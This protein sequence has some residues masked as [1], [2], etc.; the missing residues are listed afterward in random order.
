[1][2]NPLDIILILFGT[3]LFYSLISSRINESIITPPM[4]FVVVG[5]LV[6]PLAL[7]FI[8]F[9]SNENFIL[10]YAEI[11]LA[12]TL[13]TD[14]ASVDFKSVR[15][16]RLPVRLLLIGLPLTI[17]LGTIAALATFTNLS[18]GEAG[19]IGAILAPTDASLGQAIVKNKH[20][21]ERI[22]EALDVESGLN[23]GGAVPFFALF[24]VLAQAEGGQISLS[25]WAT[26]AIEQIGFGIIIGAIVGFLGAYLLNKS[27]QK[28]W[29]SARLR[30]IALI[31]LALVAYFV[32]TVAGGSGF[33]AA[34]VAGLTVAAY[35]A[36]VTDELI[37]F[38]GAEGEVLNL[39]VFFILGL[40]VALVLPAFTWLVV[41][42]A[43][44]SLTIVRILP[45]AISLIGSKLK[46]KDVLFIGWFG[47]R[48]LASIVLVIIA[49]QEAPDISHIA[50]V[51][52][53]VMVTVL[54]SV[55]AHGVTAA[56]M[57]RRYSTKNADHEPKA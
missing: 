39:G 25:G 30:P 27:I 4:I 28:D 49:F 53:V 19:L 1:L 38:A 56:P 11:A 45:V 51:V 34:Y 16:N 9:K 6:S 12:I 36:K 22:R 40:L 18:L 3:I 14:A 2:T 8:D 42:F 17:G 55:F 21:P 54:I 13:F 50:T 31:A 5:L 35:K 47:P 29:V 10:I 57:A 32:A 7:G 37:E 23:D 33:I 52:A 15:K 24:L 26:F 41:V 20:V 44:L 43:I 46:A 48:G